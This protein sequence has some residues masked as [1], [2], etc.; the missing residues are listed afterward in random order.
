M[1]LNNLYNFKN[2]IKHF[3]DIDNIELPIEIAELKINNFSWVKPII[4][5]VRKEDDKYRTLKIPNILNFCRAYEQIK[6]YD[7]FNDIQSMD[8]QRKRLSANIET[9]DFEEGEYDRQ[10]EEDFE[11][12]CIYDNLIKVD[13]KEYYGR[14]YTHN[15]D[16]NYEDEKYIYNMNLGATNGLLM[17]NY[18]S[19]FLAEKYLTKISNELKEKFSD[20]SIECEFSY[21][22]DDFYFFCNR[23]DNEKVIRIFDEVLEHYELERSEEK[24]QI[25]TY[26][27]YNNYNLVA[28]YWKKVI[29]HSN[30]R[31]IEYTS[32][33]EV[34][35]NN[36]LYFINQL[37]Y[38][39]SKLE[40]NK[41]KKVFINNFFKTK[42]FKELNLEKYQVKRYDYHQLCFIYKSSPE[43]MIYSVHKFAS[44]SKFNHSYVKKFFEVRYRETLKQPF[45]DEQL[46]YYYAMKIFG[47]DDVLSMVNEMVINSNNQILISYYLRDGLFIDSQID[48][49]KGMDNEKY[50]FQNYNLILYN[51]EL[52]QNLDSSINKFL[53]P[54]NA[55]K[56]SQKNTYKE[57]YRKNLRN[58]NEI[59]R[60][61]HDVN[62]EIDN[63]LDLKIQESEAK[64][65]EMMQ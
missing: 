41:L 4:F 31:F 45:H 29:A 13:I 27:S 33:G 61:I 44:M 24:K 23:N 8:I 46:Y 62:D 35:R 34:Y 5:R 49:L 52:Y 38:R 15:L 51:N 64:F 30:I 47:F 39:M 65:Q 40:D 53:I 16:I 21:F 37:V 63:Y 60:D 17:G 18:L 2:P 9:G 59:I 32:D 50:W 19:L 36:K 56:D 43:A 26:E 28:R 20:E 14:I 48:L 55:I 58:K 42:Y 1:N 22:S 25:W 57:F 10:L 3:I 54:Q 12:L 11:K 6:T 7:Y